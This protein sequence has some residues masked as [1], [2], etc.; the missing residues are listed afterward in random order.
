MRRCPTSVTLRRLGS[1]RELIQPAPL[2]KRCL[3]FDI[4]GTH[5]RCGYYDALTRKLPIMVRHET[6]NCYL[7]PAISSEELYETLIDEIRRTA[8]EVLCNMIP[9]RVCV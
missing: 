9:S 1:M 6:P 8:R 2:Y 5:L 3:V 7:R 4:G